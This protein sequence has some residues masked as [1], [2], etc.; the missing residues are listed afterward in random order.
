MTFWPVQI[1]ASL[2]DD[3]PAFVIG[4][5]FATRKLRTL[6]LQRGEIKRAPN[7]LGRAIT[8]DLAH[9]WAFSQVKSEAGPNVLAVIFG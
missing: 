7:S 3:N 8:T 9:A 2:F 6:R 4:R 5:H 1:L